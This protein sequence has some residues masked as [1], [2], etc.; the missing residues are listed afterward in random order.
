MEKRKFERIRLEESIEV[1]IE[2]VRSNEISHKNM[3]IYI[4]EVSFE[5]IRFITDIDF[6]IEEIISFALPSVNHL[7]FSGR[8]VWK[9]DLEAQRYHY[10]LQILNE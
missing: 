4:D 10:G 1:V 7:L 8:I 9:E 5:G 2:E 3:R 6:K